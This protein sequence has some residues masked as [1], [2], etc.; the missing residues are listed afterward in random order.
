[1]KRPGTT[2]AARGER[3]IASAAAPDSVRFAT[4]QP[5]ANSL[6]LPSTAECVVSARNA[7]EVAAARQFAQERGL[8]LLPLGAGSNV[9]LPECLEAV[10]LRASAMAI[11]VLRETGD[12][13]EFRAGA[14]HDWHALVA[15]TLERG[16]FGFEN[17]ALIPGTVGAAPVQNIGAYGREL[18]EFVI[19]VHGVDLETG[20]ECRLDA[21]ECGFSYRSSVFKNALRNRFFI[22][23]VDFRLCRRPRVEAS[24]PRLR[25][26]LQSGAYAATPEGVFAA[27][28]DIRR[29]RLPDP[30]A[31]PNVGSFFENPIVGAV[32]ADAL[33]ALRSDAPIQDLGGDRF[34]LSAAWLI[35]AS[36]M[37]G[38][39]RGPAAVSEQHA[40]VL[41]NHGGAAQD[42]I[43][44]L[45]AEVRAAVREHYG[46]ALQVEPRVYGP[47]AAEVGLP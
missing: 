7:S 30:A 28:I 8:T 39:C 4:R 27:V 20:D 37:R 44:A 24:Y 32:Q 25:E 1:M 38:F 45:A 23:A 9:V 11:E 29:A 3:G 6:A 43:L 40:L 33:R 47:A 34:K 19:A 13:V 46:V 35:E 18:E 41:E 10:V 26:A 14:G 22:T 36:G 5:V 15:T 2:R 31:H 16:W 42:D 17:L 12:S 21:R